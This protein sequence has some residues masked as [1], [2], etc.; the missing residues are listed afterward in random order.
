MATPE[1]GARQE[2]NPIIEREKYEQ[3]L[4]SGGEYDN[5]RAVESAISR[6]SDPET[7]LSLLRDHELTNE[8]FTTFGEQSKSWRISHLTDMLQD[9]EEAYG[10][11]LDHLVKRGL[12]KLLNAEEQEKIRLRRGNELPTDLQEQYLGYAVETGGHSVKDYQISRFV[13]SE[14]DRREVTKDGVVYEQYVPIKFR[15]E[16]ETVSDFGSPEKRVDRLERFANMRHE[17]LARNLI[18]ERFGEYIELREA[19]FK[20]VEAMYFRSSLS[21]EG[22]GIIFNLRSQEGA[23]NKTDSGVELRSL[24]DKVATALR[25]Y[26]VNSLCEKR[27][28]LETLMKKPGFN[29]YLFPGKE[30]NPKFKEYIGESNKWEKE[31]DE[32]GGT[33][34]KDTIKDERK[35]GERGLLT[36]KNIFAES[37]P[38]LEVKLHKAIRKMLGGEVGETA[39]EKHVN[40]QEAEAAQRMA[41]RLFRLF[42]TADVE[43]YEIYLEEPNRS[44]GRYETR[45]EYDGLNIGGKHL[46]LVYE[47]GPAA[48][49][50]GKLAHPDLFIIKSDRKNRDAA[51]PIGILHSRDYYPKFVTDFFRQASFRVPVE[52]IGP[53]GAKE[54]IIE[55]R[56]LN[57]VM[58]GNEAGGDVPGK[59][60]FTYAEEDAT[61]LGDVPWDGL[62]DEALGKID[63]IKEFKELIDKGFDKK[64]AAEIVELPSGG[65]NPEILHA[66][67]YLS[68]FMFGR[69]GN[70]F[71]LVTKTNI[72]I[73]DLLDEG[74]WRIL[75]KKLDVG[76]RPGI[77][78]DGAFKGVTKEA[79]EGKIREHNLKIIEGF[80]K[81]LHSTNNWEEVEVAVAHPYYD[82]KAGKKETVKP[83]TVKLMNVVNSALSKE[84]SAAGEK[85]KP[86]TWE[87]LMKNE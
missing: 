16:I 53:G 30:A 83:M 6:H 64:D 69:E 84:L 47:N 45:S 19:L 17:L 12:V 62:D 3:S 77:V 20:L 7:V 74:W 2:L 52:I 25:L 71:D 51:P 75:W 66:G 4:R 65:L 1:E 58:W 79:K 18:V 33:R 38:F 78:L 10:R 86:Y 21:A 13:P 87:E 37:N 85:F 43:G 28:R 60:G 15:K 48:S 63:G 35:R 34:K 8:I 11:P 36:Q 29:K 80:L 72:R 9:R 81:G 68:G 24:G 54:T 46:E 73:E 42:L 56:S 76:T 41:Y 26:L 14:Y 5:G 32:A 82:K 44:T 31:V 61:Q 27:T 67:I 23:A 55:E 59:P 49:D 40:K 39:A 50:Y 70:V 22:L 57:E